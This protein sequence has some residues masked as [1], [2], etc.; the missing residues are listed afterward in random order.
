MSYEDSEYT[1]LGAT[2]AV[3]ATAATIASV[4][5]T[6]AKAAGAFGSEGGAA[7][8]GG[9]AG[10][11]YRAPGL[12]ERL[13]NRGTQEIMSTERS[14][15]DDSLAQGKLLE[16]NMYRAL[17]LE[18]VYDRPEDPGFADV[19]NQLSEQQT[20]LNAIQTERAALQASRPG[21][22]LKGKAKERAIKQK[23]QQINR[24][25]R[26][27]RLVNKNVAALT[28][29]VET[30]G[31]VGRKVVG[32][33]PL[34][35]VADPTGSAGNAFGAALDSFNLHL[36]DALSG[37]EPL[38]PTLKSTFDERERDLRT[39]LR[40]QLG[41]DYETS[42]AGS[43]AIANFDREKSEAFAQYNTQTIQNF[44]SLSENRARA[45]QDLT[46]GRL[47]NLAFPASFRASL[48]TQ[49]EGAATARM[50][51]SSQMAEERGALG[52]AG[53]AAI[54][55]DRQASAERQQ[56]LAN[57]LAGVGSAAPSLGA[58]T[59]RGLGATSKF[60]RGAPGPAEGGPGTQGLLGAEG[61]FDIGAG[62]VGNVAGLRR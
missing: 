38:D 19:S 30:R 20:R 55:T 26:E 3:V 37:K 53:A 45:L 1:A 10:A 4:G 36:A 44:S 13:F 34:A 42:T 21:R 54:A 33:K 28:S 35:G 15:L 12:R 11:G 8:P 32:F 22:G 48:A 31:A 5:M 41:P 47:K 14:I 56:A 61:S 24:L 62:K 50:G 2:A 49:L 23:Q 18:P 39:R 43:R 25:N 16:P 57:I 59:E 7:G 17:G 40:N 51:L 58:V 9:L 6:A 29:E 27:G 46:S 60:L 52:E